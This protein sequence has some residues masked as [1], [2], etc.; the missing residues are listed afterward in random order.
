M[1]GSIRRSLRW[2]EG[3]SR[4]DPR[5]QAK[6]R[7]ALGSTPW[8]ESEVL[9]LDPPI[10]EGY[11]KEIGERQSEET[12]PRNWEFCGAFNEYSA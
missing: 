2:T 3:S 7:H 10:I 1:N 12:P 11:M 9:V 8:E 4:T 5:P 6:A